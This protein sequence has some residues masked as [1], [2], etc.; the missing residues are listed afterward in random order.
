MRTGAILAAL[1]GCGRVGFPPVAGDGLSAGDVVD[2]PVTVPGA[3]FGA[4]SS[5]TTDGAAGLGWMHAIASPSLLFVFVATRSAQ[6]TAPPSVLEVVYNSTPLVKLAAL[7]PLCGPP[8]GINDFELWYSPSPPVGTFSITV[9]LTGNADGVTALATSYTDVV[10]KTL[11]QAAMAGG[12][13]AGPTLSW[14]P[15]PSARWAIAGMMDQGGFVHTLLPASSQAMRSDTVCD[16]MDYTAGSV[17]DQL[18][19]AGGAPIAF[20]WTYASGTYGSGN[21][22]STSN[23]SHAWIAL[24]ASFQ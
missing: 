23:T 24:G 7:C 10:A 1:V 15:S 11:D 9:S 17:A 6:S 5:A 20:S 12:N 2:T 3:T 14:T 4:V 8:N 21:F 16:A 18:A 22:C 19:L 13:D